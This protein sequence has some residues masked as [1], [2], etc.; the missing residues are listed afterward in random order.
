MLHTKSLNSV[1]GLDVYTD[2][3]E[4]FGKI[5]EAI[6]HTNKIDSWKVRATARSYLAKAM[7]GAKGVIL[8]HHHVKSIGNIMII[9]KAAAPTYSEE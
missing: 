8:P 1:N 3:G 7:P 9:S 2:A 4:F 6:L 5:E